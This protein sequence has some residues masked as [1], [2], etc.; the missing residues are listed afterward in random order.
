MNDHPI[1]VGYDDSHAARAALQWAAGEAALRPTGLIVAY[2]SSPGWEWELAA[3]QINPDP[4]RHDLEHQ[5]YGPWL[6]PVRAYGIDCDARF[7]QGQP[8]PRLAEIAEIEDA[9]CIVIGVNRH[10]RLHERLLGS[11]GIYLAHHAHCPVVQVPPEA[12]RADT[13]PARHLARVVGSGLE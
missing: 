2:V 10:N 8:G 12:A 11:T 3:L 7:L 6:E 4:I 9:A 5:F 1:L 13:A